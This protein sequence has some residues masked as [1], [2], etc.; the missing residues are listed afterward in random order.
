MITPIRRICHH[1]TGDSERTN[2]GSSILLM[3]FLS[4]L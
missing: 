3:I 1:W 2:L 4:C